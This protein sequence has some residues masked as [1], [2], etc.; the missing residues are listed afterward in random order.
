MTI[1]VTGATGFVGKA[2][3]PT[4]E[5]AGHTVRP[6]SSR[7]PLADD[8]LAGC[9]AVVNLA[10]EPVA[11]RWTHDSKDRIRR[12]RVEG[13]RRLVDAM[14]PHRIQILVSGSAVGYYGSRGDKVLTEAEPPA[15]DFLGEVAAEWER[16][17]VW[18]EDFGVR[19]SRLRIGM[20]LGR[21]GGA[22]AK[23]LL[24]FKLGLGGPIGGGHQWMSWIHIQD[25]AN[26]I[27]FLLEEPTVRGPFN[28]VAPNPVTNA[29]FTS[30]L[31]K[32]L[33]RPAFIPVP[34]FAVKKLFGEM[35]RI[36]L[37][38][39]R[40]VPDAALRNGFTFEYPEIHGALTHVLA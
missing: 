2:L 18:A 12:S 28:G 8:A 38:S 32:A 39:Q 27:L 16:E 5:R 10:G 40:A 36:V 23:M 29:D 7:G 3:V 21:D 15:L 1:A 9:Q 6:I 24:P 13:T 17:A 30:A 37:A 19:V 20:V 14:R 31:G 11:Q 26:M 35:A 4:L 33:H 34:E 25:L 22:L